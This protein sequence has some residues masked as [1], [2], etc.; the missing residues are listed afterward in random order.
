MDKM[1]FTL[2]GDLGC[3]YGGGAANG[4]T[5]ERSLPGD[6]H[7]TPTSGGVN[8]HNSANGKPKQSFAGWMM[9]Q[10]FWFKKDV[11]GDHAG[12]RPDDQ[13][14]PLP[15]AAASHQRRHGCHRHSVLHRESGR[16]RPDARRNLHIRLHA[17]PVHHLPLGD[18]LS[19]LRHPYWTGHGGITPPGGDNGNPAD[20]QCAAGGDAGV[21][22]F[23]T[24]IGATAGFATGQAQAMSNCIGLGLN[25]G[26]SGTKA[27]WWPD[28]RTNHRRQWRS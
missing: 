9:Y 21:G 5:H 22:Y 19:L 10:R 12:R 2:T 18:G 24:S 1:A 27:L 8:C 25:N 23:P 20:Y 3:E 16:S 28:L 13:P 7:P 11:L 15:H 4:S 6:G 17:Q 26:G 14:R